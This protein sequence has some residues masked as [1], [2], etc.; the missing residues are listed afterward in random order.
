MEKTTLMKMIFLAALLINF[1]GSQV[2]VEARNI[3]IPCNTIKDCPDPVKCECR[4]NLCFCHPA[5][6]FVAA[7]HVAKDNPK[8]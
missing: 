4:I 6:M 1:A 8:L 3:N 2:G 7:N 5:A